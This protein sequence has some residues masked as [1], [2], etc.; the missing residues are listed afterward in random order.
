MN[1][2]TA[3]GYGHDCTQKQDCGSINA[4]ITEAQGQ[5][6]MEKDLVGFESCVCQLPNASGLNTNQFSALVSF[7]YNSGC[8][9]VSTY[10]HS[11]LEKKDYS[12][13]CAALPTTNTLGGELS[14]RRKREA[15]LCSTATNILSG[16]K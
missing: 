8:G 3:E 11:Y 2:N 9:G 13:V 1:A 6:L 7:A 15:Q 4:P 10:F 12:G 5:D 16:C 14:S